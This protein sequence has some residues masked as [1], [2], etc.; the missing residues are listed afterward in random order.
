MVNVT[1]ESDN[2]NILILSSGTRN[3]IVEYFKRE[4]NGEGKVICTDC[5]ALAPTL[6][7]ADKYYIV[8]RIDD[9]QYIDIIIDICKKENVKGLFSLIDPELSLIAKNKERFLE[10]GVLPFVSDYEVVETC[11]NKYKMYCECK[12]NNI[13]TVKSYIDIDEFK[14]DYDRKIINFPVFVK[15]Y[16]G[17]CSMNIQ[18]IDNMAD[19]E[20]NLNKYDNLMIQE[21]MDGTEYGVDVYIDM[22]SFEIISIFIKKKILMRA[23][24]TDK[25][26]SIKNDRMF[27]MVSRFVKKLGFIGQ[28]DIDVFEKDGE[29]YISE[30]NPRFGGGYPHAYECGCNFPGY[31]INN[32]KSQKNK[33]KIGL[34]EE[35]IYMMKYLDLKT[36]KEEEE[37]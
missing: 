9:P 34:Y 1:K 16:N 32:M 31:M 8:P 15:P 4:L 24:E 19:L 36:I 3:K 23:G 20:F 2:M 27:D 12:K 33:S 35:N 18:K 6:Y 17:S 13:P 25:S 21:F 7:D 26:V 29:F 14:K 22:I 28:I 30:V 5:N 37:R 11:F 10:I